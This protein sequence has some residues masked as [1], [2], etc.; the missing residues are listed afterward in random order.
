MGKRLPYFQFEPG[1]YLAGDIMFCSYA[2]QGA[3]SVLCSIYWQKD[4]QLTL[5][6]AE[7]RIKDKE[8]I[9]ELIKENIIK[10][11][12]DNILIYFLDNQLNNMVEKS[13]VN[14]K[15]GSK[16]AEARWRK[17]GEAMARPSIRHSESMA[18][19]EDKIREDK[20][21]NKNK[22]AESF[23]PC[24]EKT[25][26]K[27]YAGIKEKAHQQCVE[28]WLKEFHPGWTFG[29]VQGKALKIMLRKLE[30][31][32]QA[33]GKEITAEEITNT[34]KYVCQNLPEWYK[35]KDLQVINSKLNE[36]ITEIKNNK[37]GTATTQS[38]RYDASKSKYANF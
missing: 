31:I 1:E 28:F 29:A 11:E 38:A 13:N 35:E 37:N 25:L 6:Q 32:L 10:V 33:A 21:N 2:A 23:P 24:S 30:T 12:G 5:D 26:T 4:C 27:E 14:S 9:T 34:F 18:L 36:V 3:F 19:R 22:V 15:N 16:G 8:L 17:N 7:R 20:I